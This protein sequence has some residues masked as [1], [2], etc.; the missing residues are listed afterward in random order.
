MYRAKNELSISCKTYIMK[1][2][3]LVLSKTLDE[4]KKKYTNIINKF[5]KCNIYY[6]LI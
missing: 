5:L 6:N 2:I 3:I 1:K 4:K